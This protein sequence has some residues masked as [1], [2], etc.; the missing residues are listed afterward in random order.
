[1]PRLSVR[2]IG[3]LALLEWQENA[4]PQLAGLTHS[5]GQFDVC[6]TGIL[7]AAHGLQLGDH[8]VQSDRFADRLCRCWVEVDVYDVDV[9]VV[10]CRLV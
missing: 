5:I 6:H 3:N 10:V 2:H 9:E 7:V 8:I 4:S 1:M